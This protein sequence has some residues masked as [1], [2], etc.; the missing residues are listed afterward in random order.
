MR[1]VRLARYQARRLVRHRLYSVPPLL[2]DNPVV[3]VSAKLVASLQSYCQRRFRAWM[4]N[5]PAK[6]RLE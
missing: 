1:L 6:R 3:L 4:T 5:V 2:F